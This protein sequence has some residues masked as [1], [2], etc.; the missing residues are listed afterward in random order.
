MS[1]RLTGEEI[2]FLAEELAKEIQEAGGLE[3]Y[4]DGMYGEGA[5]KRDADKYVAGRCPPHETLQ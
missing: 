5:F 3:T 2:K 4:Y 1:K